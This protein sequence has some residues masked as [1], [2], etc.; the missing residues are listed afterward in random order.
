MRTIL[1]I[2]LFI[3]YTHSPPDPGQEFVYRR[4]TKTGAQRR[5]LRFY[6]DA[7][8]EVLTPHSRNTREQDKYSLYAVKIQTKK[9]RRRGIVI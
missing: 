9:S 5:A 2:V 1:R 6:S 7:K 3:L 8:A 4:N